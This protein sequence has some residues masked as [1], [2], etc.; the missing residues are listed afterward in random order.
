M[1]RDDAV[2]G[3]QCAVLVA[4]VLA[5]TI[6]VVDQPGRRLPTRQRHRQRVERELAR[7]P[8]AHRPAHDPAR[9]EIEDHG[10]VQPALQRPDVGDVRHPR[11]CSAPASRSA[12]PACSARS[13][14]C[15]ASRSSCES[16]AGARARRPWARIS[17]ATRLRPTCCWRSPELV[18]DA[19]TPVP[20]PT[21]GVDRRDLDG[22]PLIGARARGRRAGPP[23]IEPRAR[24]RRAPHSIG[25]SGTWPS[26]P[27]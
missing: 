12:A 19:G 23:R 21:L 20:L 8:L 14:A 10:E 6:G 2:G 22:E 18:V 3:E 4:R 7:H 25:R 13:A 1:L 9:E 24:H 16:G 11:P 5:A 27:R 17:R 26:P 15:A